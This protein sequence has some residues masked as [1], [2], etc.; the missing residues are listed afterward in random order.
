MSFVDHMPGLTLA[1]LVDGWQRYE[2]SLLL[3]DAGGPAEC[4]VRRGELLAAP[5]HMNA[6]LDQL[7][8]WVDT[9]DDHDTLPLAC[10]QLKPSERDRCVEIATESAQRAPSLAA[11]HVHVGSAMMLGTPVVF[12]TGAE[13]RPADPVPAPEP[14]C[15]DNP[16]V[17]AGILDTGLDPH[18]WFRSRPWFEP[19][20]EVLDA[21]DDRGQ[22]RQAGHGTFVSGVVLR[23]APGVTLRPR[24]VLSSLGLTDDVRVATGMCALRRSAAARGEHIDVLVVTSGCHT[25]DD[26]CPP[27]LRTELERFEDTVVVAA[28]GNSSTYRPFW[29]AALSGV[30][31]VAARDERGQVAGFSNYGDWVDAAAPGV[32][33]VSS[34]VR[35][36]PAHAEADEPRSYGFARWSG[37][38]FAAPQVAA[39][40]AT[41]LSTG[42][43]PT[44]A[45]DRACR[46]YPFG[47]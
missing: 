27:S 29:P 9:V 3:H 15:W 35:L 28:A 26:R 20:P 30:I 1:E 2:P 17:V 12:G 22:D 6:V 16:R 42:M 11:N 19:A 32:D 43:K 46:Q 36:L 10:V 4:V 18:P 40:I 21:D 5:E 7:G 34:H 41:A 31:G 33:V 38:S 39:E 44:E 47:R 45:A 8:R 37:T 23:H 13:A 14:L 25:S 24:T